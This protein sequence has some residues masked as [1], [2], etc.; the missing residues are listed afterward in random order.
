MKTGKVTIAVETQWDFVEA[1][2]VVYRY[3]SSLTRCLLEAV[4]LQGIGGYVLL[5]TLHVAKAAFSMEF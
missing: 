3:L 5:R 4:T 2:L 1:E